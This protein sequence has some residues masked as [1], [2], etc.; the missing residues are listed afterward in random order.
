MITPTWKE[1]TNRFYESLIDSIINK[2]KIRIDYYPTS[3]H[4]D[5]MD[6][7]QKWQANGNNCRL[8]STDRGLVD[9]DNLLVWDHKQSEPIAK[10][11]SCEMV[12][13]PGSR[14][15]LRVEA[16]ALTKEEK[17]KMD[18]MYTGRRNGKNASYTKIKR[19][20][21]SDP[22]TIVFWDDGTKTVVKAHNEDFD[23]EKGLAMAV[24]K[25]VYGDKY[26]RV[27]K[28]HIPKEK[29][30]EIENYE[31]A[32]KVAADAIKELNKELNA[33]KENK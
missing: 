5:L 20:I 31:N 8:F 21:F 28:D 9:L 27:F 32:F 13:G 33:G 14:A 29:P 24:C 16:I 23:P 18:Y 7:I 25:R 6:S 12:G 2:P 4:D 1:P 26:H 30:E 17:E 19:V 11:T 3:S 15:S 22:A 10:V